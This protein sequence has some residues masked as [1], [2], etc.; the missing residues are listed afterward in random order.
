MIEAAGEAI[1][2]VGGLR[3][4]YGELEEVRGVSREGR[5]GELFALLGTNGAGKTTTIEVLEDLQRPSAG[6]VRV[7]GVDPSGS[8][9]WC[10][11]VR[12]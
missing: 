9:P 3:R 8:R 1:V 4:S 10:G 5:R 12:G 7:F 2:E 11:A 6:L